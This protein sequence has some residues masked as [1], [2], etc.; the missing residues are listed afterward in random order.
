MHEHSSTSQDDLAKCRAL[1][2]VIGHVE[3][4]SDEEDFHAATAIAGSAP[5]YFFTA[6]EA[7]ADAG[8][9]LGLKR[10]VALRLGAH[11]LWGSGQLVQETESSP[12]QLRAGVAS[13]AGVTI[14]GLKALEQRSFRSVWI[15]AIE[16]AAKRSKEM[17]GA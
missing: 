1:F 7:I 2:D 15:E 14:C 11:T 17:E 13:P 16:V 6:L 3:S 8:V 4:L 5:A 12:A 9:A 10:S